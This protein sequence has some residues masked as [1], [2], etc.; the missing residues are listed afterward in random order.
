[1]NDTMSTQLRK[2]LAKAVWP[3]GVIPEKMT[4]SEELFDFAF[5]QQAAIDIGLEIES[6]DKG[7]LFELYLVTPELCALSPCRLFDETWYRYR[8]PDVREAIEVG[9]FPSGFLHFLATGIHEGRLPEE[10]YDQSTEINQCFDKTSSVDCDY[11]RRHPKSRE[12][13]RIFNWI[14]PAEYYNNFGRLIGIPPVAPSGRLPQALLQMYDIVFSE[15]NEDFYRSAYLPGQDNEDAFSHYVRYG[16]KQGHSPN[17]WFQEEWYRAFYWDVRE[18]LD[19]GGLPSGFF[20]YLTVGRAEGRLP[21]FDLSRALEARMP[22]VTDPAL[23]RRVDFL[24]TRVRRPVEV[25]IPGISNRHPRTIWFILPTLNVDIS[26]GGYQACFALMSAVALMGFRLGVICM[27]EQRPNLAYFFW[28]SNDPVLCAALREG[29]VVGQDALSELKICIEDKFIAYSVWDL[30]VAS[31]FAAR[32]H[33]KL[34]FLLAQEYEPVFYDNSAMKAICAEQY[35]YNHIPIINSNFLLDY[36][37]TNGVG[38]FNSTR[39]GVPLYYCFEHRINVLPLSNLKEMNARGRRTLVAYA[40]PEGHAARNLFEMVVLVL[41]RLCTAG[42]F[43]PEWEFIGLGALSKLPA[44]PLGNGHSLSM[45]M[46]MEEVEYVRFMKTLDIGVSMMEAPHPSIMPFEF[47]TTG[48]LVVTNTF[49][50]RT[51]EQLVDICGNFIP[52]RST[53]ADM[54]RAILDALA[55]VPDFERRLQ[56]VYRQEERHWSEIFSTDFLTSIFGLPDASV[57]GL[58]FAGQMEAIDPCGAS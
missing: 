28:R 33:G 47:A 7:M 20:H 19:S 53:L 49:E 18:S 41:Q 30:A 39:S 55:R 16:Q 29:E 44:I 25:P 45:H 14:D 1:M 4:I 6:A 2:F 43:G 3:A 11:I 40:R 26:F 42:V 37:K 17:G 23:L 51:K 54:E 31:V 5:L 10:H 56:N 46:K 32:T 9:L 48:A 50:N 38:V 57:K 36:F 27:E 12:F 22:G 35:H 15:F 24:K 52:C 21:A 34:P 8:Y 13:L 58:Q